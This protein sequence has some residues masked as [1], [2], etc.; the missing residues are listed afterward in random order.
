MM[1]KKKSVLIDIPNDNSDFVKYIFQNKVNDKDT[2]NSRI[3]YNNLLE[4]SLTWNEFAK[5][6]MFIDE[7]H[8]LLLNINTFL[9]LNPNKLRKSKNTI[10]SSSN[11]NNLN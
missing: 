10:G 11:I 1:Q 9:A 5:N 4:H 8:S 3:F 2:Y 6:E 7:G